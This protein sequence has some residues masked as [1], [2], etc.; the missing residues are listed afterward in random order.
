MDQRPTW[1]PHPFVLRVTAYA[2]CVIVV[3]FAAGMVTELLSQLSIVLLPVVVAIF[4]TR[5]LAVPG[6]WLTAHRVP[7]A[8]AAAAVLV[9]FLLL[10][11][12]LVVVV[13]PPL[14]DEF[15]GL[16]DTISKGADQVEDWIVEDSDLDVTRRDVEDIRE[17]IED[18]TQVTV[19]EST[20]TIARGARLV[21]EALVSLILALVLTFFAIKDGPE[22]QRWATG[23][24][25][26]D[27]QEQLRDLGRA[28]WRTLG[29]YLRGAT[30]LGVLEGA[31]IGGTM[32]LVGGRL[33]LPIALLTFAAAYVPLV[34][35]VAAGVAAVLVTLA[36]AGLTE[37]LIVGGVALV[38]QQLDGDL[39][40]PWIY[41]KALSMHPAVI[42]LSIT[43][44]TALFGIVGTLLA[45]PVVAIGIE[46]TA[47]LRRDAAARR[48]EAG[49]DPPVPTG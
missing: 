48:F 13:V 21:V 35:A 30:L 25:P 18:R 14:V 44:G 22:V 7:P 33:A 27:R 1:L 49:T 43:A 2:A 23:L 31:I 41:G 3:G 26:P 16:G 40:A 29:G 12:G 32:W 9:G 42:L 36:T 47:I 17:N 24:A 28:A 6:T 20:D 46:A 10:V 5:V 34:G 19:E 8:A 11:A 38:V 37:A 39:L 4:L 45:V 15:S